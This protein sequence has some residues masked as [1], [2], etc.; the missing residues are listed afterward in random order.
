[1]KSRVV[2]L[3]ISALTGCTL[4]VGGCDHGTDPNGQSTIL[5]IDLESDFQHDLVEVSLDGQTLTNSI[6]TTNDVLSLAWST[7]P[8]TTPVGDHTVTVLVNGVFVNGRHQF[9]LA[10]TTTLRVRYDRQKGELQFAEYKGMI[11]RD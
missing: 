7:G 3:M 9:T 6:M 2:V 10:D 5:S 11:L 1:M 4:L 8:R